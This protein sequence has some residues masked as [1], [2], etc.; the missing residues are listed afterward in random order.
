MWSLFSECAPLGTTCSLCKRVHPCQLGMSS[1][2][3]FGS[4]FVHLSIDMCQACE[5]NSW[6]LTQCVHLIHHCFVWLQ[7][8][9]I[10][11]SHFSVRLSAW[12]TLTPEWGDSWGFRM[13]TSSF[14][15]SFPKCL[16]MLEGQRLWLGLKHSFD[17]LSHQTRAMGE[18]VT[19]FSKISFH[20]PQPLL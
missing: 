2:D 15:I 8:G 20:T 5:W 11:L 16:G 3:V 7:E 4:F 12:I 19:P 18:P 13:P 1:S 6:Q 9:I 14:L 17:G 10:L